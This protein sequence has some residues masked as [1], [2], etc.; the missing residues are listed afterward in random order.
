MTN[1]AQPPAGEEKEGSRTDPEPESPPFTPLDSTE[2]K[3]PDQD[4]D[5]HGLRW[6][7]FACDGLRYGWSIALFL[8]LTVAFLGL[9]D[10]AVLKINPHLLDA[11]RTGGIPVSTAFISE[12]MSFLA[13]LAAGSLIAIIE[14]R[15]L[16]DYFL[17]GPSR[18]FHFA[19]GVLAGFIA[20]SVL[21]GG[22]AC[23]GWLHFGP[24]A[25]SGTQT[26]TY[27]ISWGAV[28]LLT[29]FFEEGG[30][31]CYLQFTLT[32][33]VNFWWA[34]AVVAAIC[35]YIFLATTGH[36]A[37]GVYLIAL[38]GLLPC[39]YLHL[40]KAAY[41]TFWQATWITS[42]LFGSLHTSNSGENWIGI[43]MAAL[44]GF[45]FCVSIRLTG[46]AWW[47]I[48][49]H[50]SWDWAESYFYGVADSGMIAK[51]H[52]LTT[53]PAGNGLWS[54]GADGPEGSLLAL[55]A[56]FLL[57]LALILIYGRRKPALPLPGGAENPAA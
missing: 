24:V 2:A 53:S 51:G 44:V 47:A 17:G 28:F 54:G 22:L 19:G 41:S 49:C 42:T 1:E 26:F 43:A 38:L 48:G 33:G 20:L 30:F 57:L 50:A 37:W 5:Y 10:G 16:F 46:S 45:I 6:I 56:L 8:L 12:L 3:G 39:L 29:G 55:P 32:R 27:A 18:L 7:F 14:R 31:R 4:G 52:F 21:V 36:G 35:I 11:T 40:K 23:G 25:L 9:F 34:L 15:R 13:I